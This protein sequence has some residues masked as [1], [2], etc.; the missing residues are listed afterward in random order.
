MSRGPNK[1]LKMLIKEC[2]FSNGTKKR[3]L[4]Q[5]KENKSG[6]NGL[7][8]KGG[9]EKPSREKFVKLVAMA[10]VRGTGS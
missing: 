3:Q 9:T 6:A 4:I 1:R 7:V 10:T 2:R 8:K 5:S